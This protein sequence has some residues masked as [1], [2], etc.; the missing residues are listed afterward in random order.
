MMEIAGEPIIH[1][2]LKTLAEVGVREVTVV[3]GYQ[4]H[5]ITGDF[6]LVQNPNAVLKSHSYASWFN[7][8][9]TSLVLQTGLESLLVQH[10]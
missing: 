6:H 8:T 1:H 3:G 9:T 5:K 10:I 2:L 4:S 7:H